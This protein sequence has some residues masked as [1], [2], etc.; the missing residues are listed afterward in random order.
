MQAKCAVCLKM[1]DVTLYTC[2]ARR[3]TV[4]E[5]IMHTPATRSDGF[6]PLAM[7]VFQRLNSLIDP[8]SGTE[9]LKMVCVALRKEL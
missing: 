2:F 3:F 9:R 8:F 7:A 1:P 4:A 6:A 5:M